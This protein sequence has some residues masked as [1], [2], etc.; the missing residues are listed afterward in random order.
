MRVTTAV[1]TVALLCLVAGGGTL[2]G[3]GARGEARDG[4]PGL[5]VGAQAHCDIG[6]APTRP[7]GEHPPERFLRYGTRPTVIGCAALP[8]GRRFELVGYQ[9][10]RGERTS[11]CIDHYDFDSGVTWGC[12][13]DRVYGGGAIDAT[14]TDRTPGHLP[15]VA[16]TAA[17]RVARVVVRSEIDGRLRRHESALVRVRDPKLLRAIGVRRPFG[18]YLAEVPAGARAATAEARGARGRTLGL[19]FFPGFREPVREGRECYSQPRVAR[20]RLLD[21]PRVRRASRLRIVARYPGG[22][23]GSVDVGVSGRSLVHA[24]LAPNATGRHVVTLPVRFM[25]RGP[26][27]IDVTA[28]GVPLSQRCGPRAVLRQSA[29]KTLVV[30]VR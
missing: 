21:P 27:G 9:L 11:L 30:R 1:L 25:R 24:D 16:G 14:S 29:A 13:S 26:A 22:S 7:Y 18:R 10:G 19:A 4:R 15:V 8:N 3:A 23:I 28:D 6:G 20:L 2:A 12:G 5:A 17:A